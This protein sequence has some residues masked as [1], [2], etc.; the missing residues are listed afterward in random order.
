MMDKILLGDVLH[1][2]LCFQKI[3]QIYTH[4]DM[5]RFTTADIDLSTLKVDIVLRN[6]EILE[7]V[8]Q[9]PEYD[10]KKLLESP[11]SNDELFRFFKIYYEDI[12]FKLNKYFTE[13]YFIRLSEI[14]NM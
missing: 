8:I 11:Y 3:K 1:S 5:Y 4:K 14:E 6:K 2:V 9:H 7:W 12:I 10:Y 13:D